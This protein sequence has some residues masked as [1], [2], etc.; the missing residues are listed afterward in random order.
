MMMT[1]TLDDD[2]RIWKNQKR[3]K[4]EVVWLLLLDESPISSRTLGA[5]DQN[6]NLNEMK[7]IKNHIL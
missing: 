7:M 4:L 2:E 3:L 1:T 5:M 6:S